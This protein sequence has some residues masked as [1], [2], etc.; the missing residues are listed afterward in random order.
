MFDKKS[1]HNDNVS[2]AQVQQKLRKGN[3]INRCRLSNLCYIKVS[4]LRTIYVKK[5]M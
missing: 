4:F 5:I 2:D 3:F 1:L